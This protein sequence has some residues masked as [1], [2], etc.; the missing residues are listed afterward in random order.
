VTTTSG[1]LCPYTYTCALADGSQLVVV[2]LVD[3]PPSFS[4]CLRSSPLHQLSSSPISHFLF[5]FRSLST[6]PRRIATTYLTFAVKLSDAPSTSPALTR[7]PR[8]CDYPQ[9]RRRRRARLTGAGAYGPRPTVPACTPD[10]T[11][12]ST[13]RPTLDSAGATRCRRSTVHAQRRRR[14]R[15]TTPDDAG[16]GAPRPTLDGAGA[17]A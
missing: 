10:D 7:R 6:F 11:G 5:L 13:W 8:R 2:A 16:A 1:E 14:A 15:P 17:H 4:S 9:A 12:A 3:L